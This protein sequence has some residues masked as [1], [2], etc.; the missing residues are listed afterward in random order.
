M[1]DSELAVVS[2]DSFQAPTL[3][4]RA[5]PTTRKKSRFE[6]VVFRLKTYVTEQETNPPTCFISYAWGVAEHERWVEYSLASDL[7]NAG[8]VVVLDRWENA[9]IGSSVPR[10]VERIGKCDHVIVV[11][12]PLYRRKYE[13]SDPTRGFV[14]GAEGDLVGRRMIGSEPEKLSVHPILLAGTDEPSF[15]CL[16]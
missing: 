6:Q 8:L 3:I 9:R 12:T 10:F 7:V 16:L 4:A 11:G 2:V 13:N 15:P 1:S 5:S 14:A